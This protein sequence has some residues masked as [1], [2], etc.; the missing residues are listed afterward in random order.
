MKKIN[1][2]VLA[3]TLATMALTSVQASASEFEPK[4]NEVS[5]YGSIDNQSTSPGTSQTSESVFVSYGRYFT[6]QIVG[7]VNGFLMQSGSGNS[8]TTMQDVG[9]GAKYYFAVGK[10][11]DWTPFVEGGLEASSTKSG[12]I[13]M[14]GW[15]AT[16]A[17]GV[18]YWLTEVAG[19]NVDGRYKSDSFSYAGTTFT[20]THTMAEFGLTVKF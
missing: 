8:Q 4:R 14:S 20:I 17:G 9:V 15:G 6:P 11:G 7:T 13:S 5:F 16:V 1:R 18:T 19:I 12:G 2:V 3:G 10:A